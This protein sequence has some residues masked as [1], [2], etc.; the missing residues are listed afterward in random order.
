[1]PFTS[2]R[3][4]GKSART[5]AQST[6]TI[7]ATVLIRR[8]PGGEGAVECGFRERPQ[9][10]VEPG[11]HVAAERG[12]EQATRIGFGQAARTQVEQRVRI[13]AAD[14]RAVRGLHF[15]GVD[16]EHGLRVD[17]RVFAEQQVA[18]RQRR[19]AAIGAGADQD[20][21]VQDRAAAVG[22]EAAPVEN[23]ARVAGDVVDVQARIDVATARTEQRT[24]GLHVRVLTDQAATEFVSRQ[25]A[26]EFQ[27]EAAITRIGVDRSLRARE[28]GR[29]RRFVLHAHMRRAAPCATRIV[30]MLFERCACAPAA[31]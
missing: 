23:A 24:I 25:R 7:G 22:R 27:V 10:F 18:A 30:A 5:R 19:V 21:A 26:A 28:Q 2:R 31:S 12:G 29:T 14:R 15:V 11:Q 8:A 6:S 9:R 13:E 16:F 4:S 1:L 20:A 17:L 3:R